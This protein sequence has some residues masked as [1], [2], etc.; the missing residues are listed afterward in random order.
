MTEVEIEK[1][2]KKKS[3]KSRKDS[4][5]PTTPVE[6]APAVASP[7]VS[8]SKKRKREKSG[9]EEK[10]E[11][12]ASVPVAEPVPEKKK[13]SKKSAASISESSTSSSSSEPSVPLSI[14]HDRKEGSH[15]YASGIAVIAQPLATGKLHKKCLKLVKKAAAEKKIKRGVREAVK[16]IR[17]NEKGLMVIAGNITPIDVITHLP[18]LCE[19]KD[20]PYIYV[21]AKEEL[22]LAAL[23]KRSTSCIL[24]APPKDEAKYKAFF[25]EVKALVVQATP[26]TWG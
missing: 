21:N 13:K 26:S 9:K 20:I 14:S 24:V 15:R 16:A 5:K 1:S 22:G 2:K 3:K 11:V 12:S 17:K 7:E 4:E 6:T 8:K 25:D 19:E 18:V 10:V 23:T